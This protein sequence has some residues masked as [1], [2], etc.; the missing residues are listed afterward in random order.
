MVG[1]VRFL[2]GGGP[3]ICRRWPRSTRRIYLHGL[4]RDR[5]RGHGRIGN[6]SVCAGPCSIPP[7]PGPTQ[8]APLA[9]LVEP[10]SL[11]AAVAQDHPSAARVGDALFVAWRSVG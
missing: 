8:W 10:Y 11:D 3:K 5:F 6:D 2:Q 4:R 9:P 7:S 1:G